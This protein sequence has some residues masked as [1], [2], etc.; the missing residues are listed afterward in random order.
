VDVAAL[1]ERFR[2]AVDDIGLLLVH[3]QVLPCATAL[4]AGEPVKGSWWSHELAHPIYDALQLIEDDV[5]RAKLVRGKV[6]LI[7]PRLWPALASVGTSRQ[8]WQLEGLTSAAADVLATVDASAAP[9]RTPTGATKEVGELERRLLVRTDEVHTESGR[10][11]KVLQPWSMW[12][13]SEPRA[14][15]DVDPSDAMA[16]FERAVAGWPAE[17]GRLFPWGSYS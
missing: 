5:T 1:A 2:S 11:A 8:P 17:A 12:V 9:M 6:T 3:D 4:A 7:A 15:G 13:M 10:H 16:S 14:R